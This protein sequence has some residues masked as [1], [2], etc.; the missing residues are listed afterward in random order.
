MNIEITNRRI[1]NEGYGAHLEGYDRSCN[2]YRPDTASHQEWIKG[3]NVAKNKRETII[4]FL[5]SM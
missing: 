2:P 5:E 3:Y 1:Y 4:R